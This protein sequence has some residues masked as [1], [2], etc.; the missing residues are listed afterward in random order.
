MKRSNNKY[1]PVE[2]VFELVLFNLNLTIE[3]T[4]SLYFDCFILFEMFST[5]E[6]L[7]LKYSLIN[8]NKIIKKNKAVKLLTRKQKLHS[9]QQKVKRR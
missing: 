9:N 7:E 3:K 5:I 2:F 1:T 6:S 4:N 8:A